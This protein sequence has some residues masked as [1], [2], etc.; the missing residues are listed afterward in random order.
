[1]QRGM[2]KVAGAEQE[3]ASRARAEQ[4][5]E[6]EIDRVKTKRNGEEAERWPVE[7]FG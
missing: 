1:M 6:S 2:G 3:R 7:I 5:S 4:R